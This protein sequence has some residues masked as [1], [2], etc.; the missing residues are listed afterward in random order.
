MTAITNAVST[1]PRTKPPAAPA[2]GLLGG[3]I[4]I[5]A[6]NYHVAKGENGGTGPAIETAILSALL[7]AVL[8]GWVVPHTRRGGRATLVLGI[9]SVVSL[10]V[11]WSGITPVLGA[12]T[13]AVAASAADQSK[14]AKVWRV[15]AVAAALLAVG[16]ALANSHLL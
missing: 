3:G 16:W 10:V 7:A 2:T 1:A 8:F 6:G 9:L 13:A 5:F 11:F 12:A 15:L 14:A 4:V